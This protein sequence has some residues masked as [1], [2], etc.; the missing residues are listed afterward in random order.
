MTVEP[1][2]P[3][4]P[5][6]TP[7]TT[8]REVLGNREFSAVLS[9][10]LVSMLGN[11]LADVA[12]SY[13]VFQRTGSPFEAAVA[14]SIGWLPHL[15]IGTLLSGLPDRFSPRLLMVSSDL[16]SAVVI[17]SLVIPG[18]PVWAL[19]VLIVLQGCSSPVFGAARAATLPELLTGDRYVVGQAL[20]SLVSQSAQ[21]IGYGLGAG[22]LTLVGPKTALLFDSGTFLVS[23][24]FLRL[25]TRSRPPRRHSED[26]EGRAS[27]TSDSLAGLRRLLRAPRIRSLLVL[28]WLVPL[29]GVIPEAVAVPYSSHAGD[30]PAGAAFLL[31]ATSAGIIV[32]E[33]VVARLLRPTTRVKAMAPLALFVSVP[34]LLFVW[35]PGIPV[36]A[37]LLLI[38]ALGW[39]YGLAQS[40]LLIEA[41]PEDLRGRG[42]T[43]ATS[44][45]MLTQAL[46]FFA[47]GAVA[48]WI[49]PHDVIALGG[50]LGLVT[51]GAALLAVRK[52]R[53]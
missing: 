35:R 49:A 7:R 27:L 53:A 1:E 51:T 13:L 17:A 24:L 37:A 28:G 30:G 50:I 14:F 41:L 45:M 52:A 32:G 33:V 11:V 15:F 29:V 46:G 10:W 23:S 26:S 43:T 3:A 5:A 38:A 21:I 42:L 2:A 47:G 19:L 6:L 9:A 16:F 40:Q 34:P 44:G 18:M 12:L 39:S 25:G 8:Y 31:G 20:L 48:E 22:L 4:G 36:A